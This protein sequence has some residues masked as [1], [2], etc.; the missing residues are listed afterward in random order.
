M[1]YQPF[2]LRNRSFVIEVVDMDSRIWTACATETPGILKELS[3]AP[4]A[5]LITI[6]EW[7]LTKPINPKGDMF[8]RFPLW[9]HVR[10]FP[11]TFMVGSDDGD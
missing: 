8:T 7:E 1:A 10:T 5:A 11:W 9:R 4:P 6:Y 2:S 3:N